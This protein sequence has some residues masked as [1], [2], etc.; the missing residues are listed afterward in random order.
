MDQNPPKKL[1]P[2]SFKE[3]LFVDRLITNNM[4]ATKT[5]KE[6][7]GTKNDGSARTDAVD[8]LAN[9]DIANAIEAKQMSLKEALLKQGI[10]PTKIAKKVDVLLE[11][12]DSKGDIDYSAVDKGIKHATTIFGVIDPEEVKP[13]ARTTYNFIFSAGVQEEVKKME[14]T[15]KSML[16]KKPDVQKD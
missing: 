10:N 4:N 7:F 8:M 15:I 2:L 16:I 5:I 6:V 14:D 12:V 3:E 13:L 1:K 11:A 9:P